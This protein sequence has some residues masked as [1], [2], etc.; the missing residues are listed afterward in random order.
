MDDQRGFDALF[1][2]GFGEGVFWLVFGLGWGFKAVPHTKI[3]T[4]FS[5]LTSTIK[6]QYVLLSSVLAERSL[7]PAL[8]SHTWQP[9]LQLC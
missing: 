9:A 7:A 1:C 8:P 2:W 4:H 3:Q 6:S 5:R